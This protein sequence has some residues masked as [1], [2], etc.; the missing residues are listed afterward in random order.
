MQILYFQPILVRTGRGPSTQQPLVSGGRRIGQN[1][2][3][4]SVTYHVVQRSASV[5]PG[6]SREM[7]N[8]GHHT[9][10]TESEFAFSTISGD[11]VYLKL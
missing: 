9:C 8:L 10:L 5:L 6:S 1:E 7:Q 2:S 3:K 4:R 11:S